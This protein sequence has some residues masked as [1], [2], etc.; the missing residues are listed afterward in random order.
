MKTYIILALISLSFAAVTNGD[1]CTCEE[2]TI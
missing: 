1:Q 2:L